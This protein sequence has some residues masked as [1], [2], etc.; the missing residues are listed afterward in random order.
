MIRDISWIG[1]G[2]ATRILLKKQETGSL[3]TENTEVAQ[4]TESKAIF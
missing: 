2:C 4:R 1:L 3:H